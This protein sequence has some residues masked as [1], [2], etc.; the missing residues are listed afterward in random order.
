MTSLDLDA[1]IKIDYVIPEGGGHM[2]MYTQKLHV[3]I[4]LQLLASGDLKSPLRSK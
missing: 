4:N 1:Q 3:G 2:N